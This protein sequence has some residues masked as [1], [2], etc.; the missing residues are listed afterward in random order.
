MTDDHIGALLVEPN[1]QL[2]FY[3]RQELLLWFGFVLIGQEVGIDGVPGY[4]IHGAR[5]H[6]RQTAFEWTLSDRQVVH[7]AKLLRH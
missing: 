3:T 4:H 7:D 5:E 6:S 2:L 1:R